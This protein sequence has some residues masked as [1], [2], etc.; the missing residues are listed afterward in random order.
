MASQI[1]SSKEPGDAARFQLPKLSPVRTSVASCCIAL[2]CPLVS[3]LRETFSASI[4]GPILSVGSG[5]GLLEAYMIAEKMDVIGIDL[6][7]TNK[8]LLPEHFVGLRG[9]WD[10]GPSSLLASIRKVL[11]AY[12]KPVGHV[13][14]R[15]IEQMGA[16]E[17]IV[18]IGPATD[19]S[20]TLSALDQVGGWS[21][22]ATEIFGVTEPY[23]RFMVLRSESGAC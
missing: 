21:N 22:A 17:M 12:P 1:L 5:S 6:Q 4:P 13:I 10:T 23:E 9:T 19:W 14:R 15:Y 18:W 16:L 20:E 2:S 11:F 7:N 3:A 8:Y